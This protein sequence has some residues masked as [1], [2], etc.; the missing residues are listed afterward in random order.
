M[1]VLDRKRE[2]KNELSRAEIRHAKQAFYAIDYEKS[3]RHC[4]EQKRGDIDIR[5][6]ILEYRFYE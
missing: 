1:R 4:L 3:I 2:R 5:Q 6:K